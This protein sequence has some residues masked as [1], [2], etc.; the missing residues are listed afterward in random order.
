MPCK[1]CGDPALDVHHICTPRALTSGNV[2][3]AELLAH[4]RSTF[5]AGVAIAER[6]NADYAGAAAEEDAFAN[7]RA[8]TVVG[9]DPRRAILVRLTD[10]LARCAS[11]LDKP[12]AVAD[13]SISDTLLDV[14]NYAAILRAMIAL[15]G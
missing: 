8:S 10:K 2:T 13:E 11:L 7:F 9:V 5:D 15:R 12:P 4:I 3:R 14:V 6:K 1:H